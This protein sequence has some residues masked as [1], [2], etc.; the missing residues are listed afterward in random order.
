MYPGLS[1]GADE[2]LLAHGTEEQKKTY[3][4]E[5]VS[6]QWTGTMCLTEPALRHRPGPA[7]H[8]GR[9]AG[10]RHLQD[11]RHQNLHQRR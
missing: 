8:Q 3:L 4:P 9:A 10:R 5:L 2:A 7:A 11:H 1:H 6:G